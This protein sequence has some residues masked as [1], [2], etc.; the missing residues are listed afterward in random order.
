[1]NSSGTPALVVEVYL[2]PGEFHFGDSHTRIRTLLG[3]CVAI[4]FWHPQRHIGGM[5]HYMLPSRKRVDDDQLNGKYGNEAMAM[6]MQ[7]IAR[8]KSQPKEYE[9]KLFGGGN[10]M[11]ALGIHAMA[12][13]VAQRNVEQAR[14]LAK[15]YGLTIKAESLGGSGYRQLVFELWSGDVWSRNVQSVLHTDGE[16]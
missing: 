12:E 2:Q 8:H 4:T 1:M 16:R 13:N 14:R 7:A 15:E 3:S 11:E 5:C 6:F 9:V 10:M